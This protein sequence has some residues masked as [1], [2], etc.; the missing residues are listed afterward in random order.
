MAREVVKLGDESGV[1]VELGIAGY[2]EN[3]QVVEGIE[4]TASES[5]HLE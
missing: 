5:Q 3:Y 1:E 4:E 2:R